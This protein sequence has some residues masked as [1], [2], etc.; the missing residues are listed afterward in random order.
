MAGFD[1]FDHR[2]VLLPARLVDLVIVILPL[3]RAVRRHDEQVQLI[4][5]MELTRLRLRRARHAGELLIET[6]VILNGDR[7][8]RL[9]L[10]VN[11]HALLGLHR[12]VQAIAPAAARHRAAR[13]F[14][15]DDHLRLARLLALL[16]NA[17]HHV[18]HVALVEAVGAE[19]LRNVMHPLRLHIHLRLHRLFLRQPLLGRKALVLLDVCKGRREV[20]QH[21]GVRII[22]AQELPAHLHQ[23]RLVALFVYAVIQL[24]LER[25][26]RLLLRIV[27][28]TE[29]R[30]LHG[31]AVFRLLHHPHQR[32]VPRLTDLDLKEHMARLVMLALLSEFLRLLRHLIEQRRLLLHQLLHHRLVLVVL[33]RILRH[34]AADD[35][36]R[37]GFINEH[38][39]HF[40]H[41]GKPMPALHLLVRAR[42]QTIVA[43]V[44]ET[45]LR[46]RAVGHIAGIL[47]AAHMRRLV[48]LDAAHR[49]AQILQQKAHPFRVPAGEVIIH[50]NE[51]HAA[52]GEAIQ[53]QRQRRHQRLALTRP[54]L[55]DLSVMQRHAA[56]ELHI[57]MHHLPGDRLVAHRERTAR[58]PA[59]RILHHRKRLWQ[60]LRQIRLHLRKALDARQLLLPLRRLRLERAFRLRLELFLQFAH[61]LHQRP[62]LL[63]FAL[64]LRANDFAEYPM[65]HEK[66][67][68]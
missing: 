19:E 67:V 49:Q 65:Q 21:K 15:K 20:R 13:V 66:V 35:E 47:L 30:L 64:V 6:E 12:L 61:L 36:R 58:E 18:I 27:I 53:I 50:R 7:R 37:A 41:D 40:I 24:L 29:F 57:K 43:Q 48:V 46:V 44:I 31:A 33:V 52:P 51:M 4:D 68:W 55:C 54:H 17:A 2:V 32:A 11:A 28:I 42:G 56:D 63:E 16:V 39:I 34:R 26:E 3:D 10:L 25:E 45:K 8:Q 23:V 60:D 38:A 22:R 62:E 1:H 59:R 5:V 14:I 9:R